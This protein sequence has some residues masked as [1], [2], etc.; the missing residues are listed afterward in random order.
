VYLVVQKTFRLLTTA[1]LAE[2]YKFSA[3]IIFVSMVMKLKK[4]T[5]LMDTSFFSAAPAS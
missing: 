5:N 2:E 4:R 1:M 3:T